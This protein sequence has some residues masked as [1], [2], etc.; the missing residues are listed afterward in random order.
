MDR[1]RLVNPFADDYQAAAAH[2]GALAPTTSASG[3]KEVRYGFHIPPFRSVDHLHLHCLA[4]PFNSQL[5][6]LK[7]RVAP[8]SGSPEAPHKGWGWFVTAEQAAAILRDGG[9]VGVKPC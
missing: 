4:L 8:G 2:N 5:K 3:P 1:E 9:E 6:A 7:Y